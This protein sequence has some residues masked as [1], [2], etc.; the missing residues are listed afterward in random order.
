MYSLHCSYV[1]LDWST[2]S[3]QYF[4][5]EGMISPFATREAAEAYIPTAVQYHQSVYGDLYPQMQFEYWVEL[6]QD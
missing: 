3:F 4:N 2:E 5:A 6:H 1:D